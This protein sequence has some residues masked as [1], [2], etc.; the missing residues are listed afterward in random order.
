MRKKRRREGLSTKGHFLHNDIHSILLVVFHRLYQ[1]IIHFYTVP[2]NT[3]T[4]YI[5]ILVVGYNGALCR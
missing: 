2:T 4:T 1:R 3:T 5:H